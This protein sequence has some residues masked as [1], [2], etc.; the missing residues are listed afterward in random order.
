MKIPNSVQVVCKTLQ[1]SG[2]EAWIVGG[3]VRD[4]IMGREAHDWDLATNA[5]PEQ[6]CRL[7]DKVIETGIQHGTVTVMVPGDPN[8]I[9]VTT[10]R[11]DGTYSDGR[12]PDGVVFKDTIEEDLS[13][14]DFTINAIALNPFGDGDNLFC[15]PF[16]GRKDIAAKVIRTVGDPFQRFAEDGLR[17]LRAARFAATLN[18]RVDPPT[19]KAIE[20]SLQSFAKVSVE[21][22]QAEWLKAMAADKP[23]TAFHIM[24]VTGMLQV[25]VPEMLPMFGCT[26]NAYHAYD[27]WQHTMKV[28]DA[29]S[30]EDPIL[31]VAALFHDICKPATKGTHKETGDA[32]F[33]NHEVEGAD[34]TEQILTR[35]KFST[36]DKVRIVHLIRHHLIHYHSGWDNSAIRRWVN[37]VGLEHIESLCDLARADI[38]GKGPA[39]KAKDVSSINELEDRIRTLQRTEVMPTSTRVLALD[40]KVLMQHFGLTPGPKV[41]KVLRALLGVVMDDPSKNTLEQLL[42][43]AKEVLNGC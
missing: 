21:R 32:T 24:M 20:S 10:Y 1:D 15:D 42:I 30:V 2:F 28:L 14:R 4:L 27:V 19:L 13:R 8:G 40:G 22:V 17:V 34:L 18:F 36:V 37:K 39:K 29:C 23:S 6:V 9:E 3:A 16:Q 5:R 41:G 25:H 12:H 31:R 35:L 7:F 43:A 26:Q 33:Y 38:E 11:G